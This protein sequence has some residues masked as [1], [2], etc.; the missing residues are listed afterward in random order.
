MS[1]CFYNNV[2]SSDMHLRQVGFVKG[3]TTVDARVS[4][5]TPAAE[6]VGVGEF[7]KAM[8]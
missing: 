8:P 2:V 3:A 5:G 7:V 6:Q 4:G 1:R